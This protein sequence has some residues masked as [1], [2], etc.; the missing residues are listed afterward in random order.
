MLTFQ[1]YVGDSV[2]VDRRLGLRLGRSEV[3][4]FESDEWVKV[5]SLWQQELCDAG[6]RKSPPAVMWVRIDSI[7]G[8]SMGVKRFDATMKPERAV[9]HATAFD[10]ARA[11]EQ[12]HRRRIRKEHT[13]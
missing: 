2:W 1:L 7:V 10:S 4:A 12:P 8:W 3:L 11:I 9:L 6:R 5:R 13:E